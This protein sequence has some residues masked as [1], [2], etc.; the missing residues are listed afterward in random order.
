MKLLCD[1]KISISNDP[2]EVDVASSDTMTSEGRMAYS[3]ERISL[4]EAQELNTDL[5]FLEEVSRLYTRCQE[6]WNNDA[7][8]DLE[9]IG[10][11]FNV[12]LE[13]LQDKQHRSKIAVKLREFAEVT[14]EIIRVL[15]QEIEN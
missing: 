3:P 13:A 15:I 5:T 10:G 11:G 2:I 9:A 6:M 7:G 8:K 12:T 4:E 14:D 1:Q